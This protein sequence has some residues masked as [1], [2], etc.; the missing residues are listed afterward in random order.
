MNLL[1]IGTI[2][3]IIF[4]F[5][6]W[7]AK[8]PSKKI[9]KFIRSLIIILSVILAIIMVYVGKIIFS[10]P[11]MISG[12]ALWIR[13]LILLFTEDTLRGAYIQ[14]VIV[15]GVCLLIGVFIWC[16]GLIGELLAKNRQLQEE[17]LYRIKQNSFKS[18]L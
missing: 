17:S 3:I 7:F 18:K 10:L 13:Y 9:S 4:L 1:L 6:S 12:S 15:G 16:L 2:L 14:S 5:I 8:T 11:F